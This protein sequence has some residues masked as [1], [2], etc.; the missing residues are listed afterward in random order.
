MHARCAQTPHSHSPTAADFDVGVDVA[1]MYKYLGVISERSAVV[2]TVSVVSLDR[3]WLRSGCFTPGGGRTLK[4][5]KAR[6]ENA[7]YRFLAS[8]PLPPPR[9]DD[10]LLLRRSP[11]LP[12]VACT[13]T[14]L[15][16]TASDCDSAGVSWRHLT[17]CWGCDKCNLI[18]VDL[19]FWSALRLRH[20][21]KTC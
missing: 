2:V 5:R 7:R 14:R 13:H 15:P 11:A 3:G 18:Y 19:L 12:D 16:P 9:N 17:G 1:P 8:P 20:T 21:G 6:W 10:V 4:T